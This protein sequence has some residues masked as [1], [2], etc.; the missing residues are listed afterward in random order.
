[1]FK[2]IVVLAAVGVLASIG[3]AR[4][5][6]PHVE[7]SGYAGW[8]F[9]D[10]VSGTTVNAPDG[11]TYDR[12]DPKDSA[13]FGFSLGILA[14]PNAEVGFMYG[15]Q[16]SKLVLGGT[17]DRELGD[18]TITSY[19]GYF[20]Y[21][22]GHNDSKVRPFVFG[23]IGATS[24]GSVDVTVAGTA[25]NIDSQTKFST[26]WGGGVKILP[27]PHFGV[28]LAA[29]WTPTYVKSDAAGWWCDPYW[30]CYLASNAQYANQF[31]V[32]GGVS[33]RF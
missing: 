10:G 16:P 13:S 21:N 22:F 3:T 31:Q 18:M 5:Q 23:G 32:S 24:F 29:Q 9:A 14:G 6:S 27:D 20:G 19:H 25:H 17:A 11:N 28:R 15:N 30:G 4:A 8:T 26:T 12:I 2:R 7:V 33:V 1:M